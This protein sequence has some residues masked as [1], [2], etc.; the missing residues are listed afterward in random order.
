MTR[1]AIDVELLRRLWLADVR[2]ADIA[3]HVGCSRAYVIEAVK[4]AGIGRGIPRERT[5]A[6][7]A[8]DAEIV[9]RVGAGEDKRA[10]AAAYG[11]VLERVRQIVRAARRNPPTH[12]G[13]CVGATA[14]TP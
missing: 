10:V 3:A 11:I 5:E 2:V 4:R 8:R 7:A 1:L 14:E 6:K 9:R 13:D 12:A